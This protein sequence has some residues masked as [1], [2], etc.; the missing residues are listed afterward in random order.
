MEKVSVER[1]F[2]L[3][4]WCEKIQKNLYEDK[5]QKNRQSGIRV[6]SSNSFKSYTLLRN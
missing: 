5:S 2:R 6:S 3:V 1:T 4:L